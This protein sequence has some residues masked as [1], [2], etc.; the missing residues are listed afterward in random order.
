VTRR[1]SR[2]RWPAAPGAFHIT[3]APTEGGAFTGTTR[4]PNFSEALVATLDAAIEGRVGSEGAVSF[5]KRYDGTGG[6]S[7][8]VDYRGRLAPDGRSLFG[9]WRLE[10]YAGAFVLHLDAPARELPLIIRRPR[11]ELSGDWTGATTGPGDD[12]PPAHLT[13]ELEQSRGEIRGDAGEDDGGGPIHFQVA[14]T[15]TPD[16]RLRMAFRP[17]GAPAQ[18]D[19]HGWLAPNERGAGGWWQRGELRGLWHLIRC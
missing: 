13:V 2:A 12:D 5:T 10:G 17:P 16:G 6:V 11:C 1:R 9:E 14:G 7:H 19:C 15:V 18:V 8:A 3:I 4:E